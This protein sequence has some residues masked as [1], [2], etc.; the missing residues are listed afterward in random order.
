VNSP[1]ANDINTVHEKM[2][3]RFKQHYFIYWVPIN[4]DFIVENLSQNSN[5][6]FK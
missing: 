4:L 1:G 6:M 3:T 5:K 2:S